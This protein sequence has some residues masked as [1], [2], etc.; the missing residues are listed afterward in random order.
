MTTDRS[1]KLLVR[2]RMAV[3][4]KPYTTAARE[5]DAIHYLMPQLDCDYA[6]AEA[7]LDDP[8]N[9]ELCADCGWTVGMVCPECEK[10]CGCEYRC[11][12]WRHGEWNEPDDDGGID[13]VDYCMGCGAEDE[14]F[15]VC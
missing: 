12:G 8:R 3:T 10:G 13:S 5:V 9:Q 1:R 7:Y 11:S 2:T 15:C 14:E 6:A 4:G